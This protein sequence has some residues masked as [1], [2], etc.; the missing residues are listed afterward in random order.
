MNEIPTS[1][2]VAELQS[3]S[4]ASVILLCLPISGDETE[5]KSYRN[6]NRFTCLGMLQAQR[7]HISA[8]IFDDSQPQNGED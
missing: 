3:R 7:D 5:T 8:I 6:G 1:E 2:I 4:V